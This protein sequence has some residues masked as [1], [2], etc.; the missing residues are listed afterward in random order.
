M[1]NWFIPAI[2]SITFSAATRVLPQV[3]HA[4]HQTLSVKIIQG[5]GWDYG[6]GAYKMLVETN[7]GYRFFV[8]YDN[9]L[10]S[11][12]GSSVVVTS[13]IFNMESFLA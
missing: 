6:V 9:L 10:S 11:S 5:S 3:A 7:K 12:I 4:Q 1:K 2:T 13:E 8:W